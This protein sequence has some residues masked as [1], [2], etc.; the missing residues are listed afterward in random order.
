MAE[1]ALHPIEALRWLRDVGADDAVLEAPVDRYQAAAPARAAEPVRDAPR[2]ETPRPRREM[3]PLDAAPARTIDAALRP[4]AALDRSAD[5]ASAR[6]MAA[7]ANSL[8]ALRA[9]L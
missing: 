5:L 2:E 6:A 7:G 1:A 3:T 4:A 9:A 8:A